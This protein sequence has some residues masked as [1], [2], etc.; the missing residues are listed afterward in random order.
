MADNRP[1]GPDAAP[2][3]GRGVRIS[4]PA[5]IN[6]YL[7]VTGRRADGYHLLDSLV[8]FAGIADE[9]SVTPAEGW[10]LV[11]EGPF[12]DKI[13]AGSD[14]LVA[15]AATAL[16][17]ICGQAPDVEVR[18]TKNLPPAAG[19]G[20]GSADAAAV[21][22]ALCR[23]WQRDPGEPA[24]QDLALSLGADVPVCLAGRPVFFGG[25]G[26]QLTAAPGLPDCWLVLVNPGVEVPTPSVF[27][28][29]TGPFSQGGRFGDPPG[30]VAE[31]AAVLAARGNDLMAPALTLAPVIG[32]VLAA[33][34]D[35]PGCL[36]ARMS[37]SGATCFGLFAEPEGARR[38]A[39]DLAAD[40]PDWWVEAAPMLTAPEKPQSL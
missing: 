32:T 31:L 14:N 20:G 27:R 30:T 19:I 29:R 6:L 18:L 22:H 16:A 35:R 24:I 7:H 40:Y 2:G 26:E 33:L 1:V 8:V 9:L 37:G 23:I 39:A 3:K 11:I 17:G 15:K 21:L 5:K 38:A 25:V 10:S 28:A 12:A 34:E 4:A 13:P 36:L